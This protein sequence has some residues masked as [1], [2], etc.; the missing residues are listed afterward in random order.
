MDMAPGAIATKKDGVLVCPYLL[1][2]GVTMIAD[3]PLSQFQCTEATKGDTLSLIR[4]LNRALATP[5]DDGLLCGN[6]ESKWSEFEEGLNRNLENV[7]ADPAD[8]VE[9]DSDVLAGYQLPAEARTLLVIAA[10]KGGTIQTRMSSG[11]NTQAGGQVLNEPHNPRSEALWEQAI[12][13]LVGCELLTERGYKGEVFQVSAK[14]Y[15]VADLLVTKPA[16]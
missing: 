15:E 13:D 5:H 1:G 12:K 9:S 8:F 14:G 2:V 3:G 10:Q 4:S 11:R 6:F 7:V 16:T